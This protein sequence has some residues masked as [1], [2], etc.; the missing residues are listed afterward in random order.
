MPSCTAS[1]RIA[2]PEA[3]ATATSFE[4]SHTPSVSASNMSMSKKDLLYTK[5]ITDLISRLS[6]ASLIEVRHRDKPQSLTMNM[7]LNLPLLLL[8]LFSATALTAS[9]PATTDYS[10]SI[11]QPIDD[12]NGTLTSPITC[13]PKP[14]SKY[15]IPPPYFQNCAQALRQLPQ[16]EA[17]GTF[18]THGAYDQ[19]RLP[20]TKSS[21]PCTVLV[22]T[23]NGGASTDQASWLLVHLAAVELSMG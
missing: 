9:A 11:I 2:S 22:E 1:S 21:G 16:T 18:H 19:Y 13:F 20:I 7:L 4:L 8:T 5:G 17:I 10:S 14:R 6:P 15:Y 3:R 12:V 23:A